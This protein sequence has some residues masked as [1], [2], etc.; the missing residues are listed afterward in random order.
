M[1]K[2]VIG[3][4]A[5]VLM[6]FTASDAFCRSLGASTN[7]AGDRTELRTRA[8]DANCTQNQDPDGSELHQRDRDR[9]CD[10]SCDPVDP[11][12]DELMLW[13]FGIE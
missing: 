9:D 3:L 11:T 2:V 1:R 13:W 8:R 12:L 5:V 10:Q 7:G 6:L 4:C